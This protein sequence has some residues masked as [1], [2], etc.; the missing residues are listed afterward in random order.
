MG[1][2]IPK[3]RIQ[4]PPVLA[5]QAQAYPGSQKLAFERFSRIVE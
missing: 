5:P 2:G 3:G 1:L 4:A